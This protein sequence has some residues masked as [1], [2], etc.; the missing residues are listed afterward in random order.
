MLQIKDLYYSIGSRDLLTGVN[1]MIQP[2]K[3]AA[4]IGP[5]GA[6]KTTLLRILNGEIVQQ[7]GSIIKPKEFRIG[8]L[9]QEEIALKEGTVL[10]TV[11]Q[12]QK[13]IVRLEE[14]IFEM[15]LYLERGDGNHDQVLQKLGELEHQYEALDGYRLESSAKAILSGLGFAEADFHQSLSQLSGGWRMRCYLARLLLQQPNL[16]L[17][18]EPTNHLDLPSLEWLEQYLL[19][20]PGSIAIVSHDRYFIDRLADEIYELDRGRM[21]HYAGN[22][23]FYEKEKLK[24]L[25]LQYKKYE[26]QTAAIEQQQRFINRF[27]YKATKAVQ[28]QSRIKQLEKLDRIELPPPPPPKL[29]FKIQVANKSYKDVLKIEKMFF[30]YNDDWVL[31]HVDLSVYR[32]QK[33]ALVGA[34]GAG[35]TT[36]TR[37]ISGQLVPQEG[38]IV[39][40]NRTS[41]GYYAQHQVDTLDLEATV[42]DEVAATVANSLLH[43]VRNVLGIFQLRGDDAFK[44]IKVLSGGEKA[45]VSLAKILLSP[46][47]FLIMDE[48]TNH[49]DMASKEALEDALVGYDGTLLLI[50]HDRY[51]LDKIVSRVV[52]VK[53][54]SVKVYEG[55]YSDYLK[56]RQQQ[57]N[58]AAE[59]EKKTTEITPRKKSKEEKRREA[60]ARQLVSKERNLLQGEIGTLEK[61][62]EELEN[63]KKEIED[64]LVRPQTYR[65]GELA[66]RL[67]KEYQNVK[68]ELEELFIAWEKTQNDYEK[69]LEKLKD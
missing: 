55:N 57:Q 34:N 48:P 22:Y 64:D 67:Q 4:L 13:E 21:E 14:K 46:V 12:G 32:G 25:E 68:N 6:G 11:L 29:D 23:H 38:S 61:R 28:V 56:K 52:E 54:H 44:K 33:I 47:N 2:G 10:Q 3:R 5:N 65:D 58:A 18:D 35:K 36:L 66:A 20:F 30:R 63:R 40:G 19:S 15:R 24:R 1:W 37:L 31:R 17:L 7:S 9:P 43:R 51:F 49:L 69:L 26:E 53:D 59:I 41:I 16:L 27:R 39:L 45:R 42:Y 60:K 62:I 8:Y 50:S